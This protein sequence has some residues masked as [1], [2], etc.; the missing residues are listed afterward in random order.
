MHTRNEQQFLSN[1]KSIW[2][3]EL[4]ASF[5]ED[6]YL[7]LVMEYIPGGF[8]ESFYKKRHSNEK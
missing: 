2:I 7:Y 6:N 5:Q 4:K 1:V 8:D 3:V